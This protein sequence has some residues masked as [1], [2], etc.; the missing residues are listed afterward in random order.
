[1]VSTIFRYMK[2]RI[3]HNPRSYLRLLFF[4]SAISLLGFTGC[5]SVDAGAGNGLHI[6][7][8]GKMDPQA[9]Q[10]EDVVTANRDWL[11]MNH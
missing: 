11:Q 9:D 1:M 4:V 8:I 2:D 10:D 5:S 6:A 7:F 3:S